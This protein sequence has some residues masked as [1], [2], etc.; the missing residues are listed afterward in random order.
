M[1]FQILYRF[2]VLKGSS[3]AID[4]SHHLSGDYDAEVN[5]LGI[6]SVK[7]FKDSRCCFEV[8]EGSSLAVVTKATSLRWRL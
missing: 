8:L 1:F 4:A 7:C 6:K 5:R 3:L 2:E